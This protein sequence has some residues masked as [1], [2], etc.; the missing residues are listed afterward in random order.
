MS[1]IEEAEE[2]ELVINGPKPI[3]ICLVGKPNVGKSSLIN[4]ILGY[5][6]VIVSPVAHTTRE[7]QNTNISFKDQPIT[8]IDTAGISKKGT[9]IKGL[10]KYGIEKSLAA[11]RKSKLAFLVIDISQTID[12]QDVRLAMEIIEAKKSILIIA[13]KWDLV[14]EKDTKKYTDY[15]KSKFPFAR[16]APIQFVSALTKSKVDK[17]LSLAIEINEAKKTRITDAQLDRFLSKIVKLHRPSKGKGTKYPRIYEIKQVE[18]D[19]PA[20]TL[21]IGSKEDLHFSYVRFVEN[22]LRELYGY[23]GSPIS[24]IVTKGKNPHGSHNK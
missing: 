6:R 5:E 22:R 19:H 3:K 21:R 8:L 4:A 7:P 12:H 2:N 23:L 1:E 15:I 16:F 14:K 11:L 9:K 20:F 10:Q 17:A 18:A 24:I 13:N